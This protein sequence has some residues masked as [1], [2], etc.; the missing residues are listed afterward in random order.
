MNISITPK[1]KDMYKE[2]NISTVPFGQIYHFDQLVGEMKLLN[3]DWKQ[4]EKMLKETT[5]GYCNLDDQ[6]F[7]KTLRL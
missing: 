7:Y 1:N 5:Q 3:N 4:F 6:D 2:L